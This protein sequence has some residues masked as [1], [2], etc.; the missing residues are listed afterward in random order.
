MIPTSPSDVQPPP[1]GEAY[2]FTM[3]EEMIK[4]MAEQYTSQYIS[5]FKKVAEQAYTDGMKAAL[6]YMKDKLTRL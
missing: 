5:R 3:S 2:F 6:E 1:F 4:G